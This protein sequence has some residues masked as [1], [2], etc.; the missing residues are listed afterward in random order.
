MIYITPQSSISIAMHAVLQSAGLDVRWSCVDFYGQPGDWLIAVSETGRIDHLCRWERLA[1]AQNANYF[2]VHVHNSE[3]V[4][5]PRTVPDKEGCIVCWKN[6]FFRGRKRAAE[7]YRVASDCN[8]DSVDPYMTAQAASVAAQIAAQQFLQVH[9]EV[10]AGQS[11]LTIHYF[12]LSTFTGRS[13]AFVPDPTCAQCGTLP[14]D[15]PERARIAIHSQP[16]PSADADRLRSLNELNFLDEAFVGHFSNIISSRKFRWPD[17]VEAITSVA[18]P[19]RA[20]RAIEPCNG[21]CMR[22][23]DADKVAVLEGVERYCGAKPRNFKP[24][25]FGSY[26]KYRD[27]AVDPRS[28][29]LH[30][31]REY[32]ANPEIV[33]Y[34]DDLEID[35]VWAHS[36]R[37]NGPVLVPLDL[38]FYTS[39]LRTGLNRFIAAEGSS[40]CSIGNSVEEAIL[41]GIFEVAERDAF[42]LVWYANLR[43]HRLDPMESSDPEIRFWCRKLKADGFNVFVVDATNDLGIPAVLV[44]TIRE[45]QWPHVMCAAGA[46]LQPEE[47]LKKSLRELYA[48]L[49]LYESIGESRRLEAMALAADLSLVREFIQH[50]VAHTTLALV[51]HL[52]CLRGSDGT[53]SLKE[54]ETRAV[55]LRSADLGEELQRMVQKILA[56][57]CDVIA[58]DQTAPDERKYGLHTFKVL[59]PGA[60]SPCW[61]DQRRRM[62]HLSRLDNAVRQNWPKD[63]SATPIANPIPHPFI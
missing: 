47:A 7:Y 55:D 59:I 32:R 51:P 60:L 29:G 35:F 10:E 43:P 63:S 39:P 16:K 4:I 44:L 3:V 54:M 9:A 20:A 52:E 2:P 56:A 23:S 27:L 57:G 36:F 37:N 41:H 40:G 46:H 33:P 25:F 14:A 45:N 5:G 58:V 13:W 19:L 31:E 61:G 26:S 50:S 6:R 18:V 12:D 22:Y 28:F 8:D 15:T 49:Q 24:S 11:P 62:Q 17:H 30:S 34:H 38:G 48:A 1:H 53:T 42:M 21:F